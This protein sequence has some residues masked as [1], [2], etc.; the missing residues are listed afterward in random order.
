MILFSLGLNKGAPGPQVAPCEG[1]PHAVFVRLSKI[2]AYLT[3]D[4]IFLIADK[5]KFSVRWRAL[6]PLLGLTPAQIE[7]CEVDSGGF[8]EREK[9]LKMLKT[10]RNT[11]LY[12]PPKNISVA[13]LA[14]LVYNSLRNVEMLQVLG[15]SV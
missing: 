3:D 1:Q 6:A 11:G 4:Q 15:E 9:C 14:D 10:W 12:G 8:G 5:T 7:M 13:H 2:E